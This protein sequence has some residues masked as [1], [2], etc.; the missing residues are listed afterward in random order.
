MSADGVARV[1]PH[2]MR[3]EGDGR[4][5][6][7]RGHVLVVDDERNIRRILKM[8]L[9][10]E[11]ADV[12]EAR[13]ATEALER[14]GRP[15]GEVDVVVMDVKM[16]GMSGI[17][18]LERLAADGAVSGAEAD[19]AFSLVATTRRVGSGLHVDSPDALAGAAHESLL[20]QPTRRCWR[21]THTP[22]STYSTKVVVVY[23]WYCGYA[24]T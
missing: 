6:A 5:G 10:S 9:E 13:S 15:D 19:S 7:L 3:P 8:V 2:G 18:A 22:P 20:V 24:L 17:E 12:S 16:P 11:G 21:Q 4:D 14:L 23:V 1:A